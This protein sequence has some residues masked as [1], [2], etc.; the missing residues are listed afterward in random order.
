VP[1]PELSS[2]PSKDI[3]WPVYKTLEEFEAAGSKVKKLLQLV[4]YHLDNP[5]APQI[6]E[7]S[8]GS[9]DMMWPV[10]EHSFQARRAPKILVY[11]YFAAMERTII[12]VRDH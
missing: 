1:I 3:K 12:S 6:Q 8:D 9:E 4:K 11:F 5:A 10:C 7:W 2:K